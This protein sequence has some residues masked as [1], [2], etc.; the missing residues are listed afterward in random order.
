MASKE[1][2]LGPHLWARPDSQFYW[3][4]M[5]VPKRYRHVVG[6]AKIQ[7]SL[8]TANLAEA[9]RLR[10][11]KKDELLAQWH[12]LAFGQ[13]D[14]TAK[15]VEPTIPIARFKPTLSDLEEAAVAIG[16]DIHLE[17][18][19]HQR[20][21]LLSLGQW[22]LEMSK[23]SAIAAHNYQAM[24]NASEN[25]LAVEDRADLAIHALGF[26]ITKGSDD[27]V[28]LCKLISQASFAATKLEVQ[29]VDGDLEADTNSPLV[30]RVR[31]REAKVAPTGETLAEVFE[32]WASDRLRE[33]KKRPATVVEDR[34]VIARFADFVG[35]RRSAATI[36]PVEVAEFRDVLKQLPPKWMSKKE[37]SGKSMR[38]AAVTARELGL[39]VMSLTNVNKQ[40][41]TISPLFTWMAEQPKWAGFK[42]P[43][44]GLWQKGAKG[45]NR[46]PP[47]SSDALSAILS[48]PLFVGFEKDGR[49]HKPGDQTANDWRTWVPLICM[50][51]GARI[52]EVAQMRIGDVTK[53]GGFWFFWIKHEPEEGMST[54][55][56]KDRPVP[57]HSALKRMGFLKYVA[58]RA[59]SPSQDKDLPLF[60]EIWTDGDAGGLSSRWWRN[61]LT[62]IKLK[63]GR[64][65]MGAHSFRHTLAD[66]LRVEAELLDTQVAIYLGHN[67]PS[68]TSGYGQVPQGTAKM[69]SE[70]IERVT[71][72]GV[73]MEHLFAE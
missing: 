48:S 43:C 7:E 44:L 30:A 58:S 34:K 8:G 17:E 49:E 5:A 66:R 20:L 47:F 31:E 45:R 40:L 62:K 3:F 61:Y 32:L 26:E 24:A 25:L 29:R 65:G 10:T 55:S 41:S 56:G 11:A 72:D 70:W 16:Y 63:S 37:L 52:G 50:F 73:A 35:K 27:Y 71:F 69:L 57:M 67:Q 59:K 51:T 21:G 13:I 9:R 53:N 28:K 18:L 33:G 14:A 39:G 2:Q 6:K 22:G 23:N 36:T 60:S 46:R 19:R 15:A 42:N 64:D 4:R 1:K 68:T 54:K 12:G 38:E